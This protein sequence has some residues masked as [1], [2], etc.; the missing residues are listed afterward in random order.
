LRSRQD[1]EE[2]AYVADVDEKKSRAH[3]VREKFEADSSNADVVMQ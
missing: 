1:G 3:G 2:I